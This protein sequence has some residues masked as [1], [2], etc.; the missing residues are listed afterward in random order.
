MPPVPIGKP[1]KDNLKIGFAA[2]KDIAHGEELF[3]D[4]G[5]KKDPDF[6]WIA[7][8]AKDI[9]TSLEKLDSTSVKYVNF[10]HI[11][12]LFTHID[13]RFQQ[14]KGTGHLIEPSKP[15]TVYQWWSLWLEVHMHVI[16]KLNNIMPLY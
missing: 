16:F 14:R 11:W 15:T 1:T 4:Y 2:R 8:N 9:R 13:H 12:V 10:H 3:T 7:T 6:P 5:L